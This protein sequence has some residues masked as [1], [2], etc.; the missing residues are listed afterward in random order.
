MSFGVII[1]VAIG[2]IFVYLLLGLVGSAAQEACASLLNWRGKHLQQGLR[3]LLAHEG[4]GGKAGNWLFEAVSGH[5]MLSTAGGTRAPSYVAAGNFGMALIESLMDGSQAPVFTQ[6]ERSVAQLPAGRLKQALTALLN[7]AGGDLDKFRGGVE[8]WFDDGMDRVSGAY[9]RF[10]QNFMLIFGFVIAFGGNFDTIEMTKKLWA[11]P[12]ARAQV[13]EQAKT[14]AKEHPDG[15][16]PAPAAAASSVA[17]AQVASGASAAAAKPA[18][19]EPKSL[20]DTVAPVQAAFDPVKQL[21][22]PFGW[23]N[24]FDCAAFWSLSKLLGCAITA[25]AVALG[26]PFWFDTLQKFLNLRA[27]GPKPAKSDSVA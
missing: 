3:A 7:Q 24:G 10:S 9:K 6:V 13:M 27:A 22:L 20:R 19:A 25:L 4:F 26:A 12:V 5:G 8:R 2:L 18:A 16:A 15:V 1:D 11:D 23:P 14:F 17:A 21:P